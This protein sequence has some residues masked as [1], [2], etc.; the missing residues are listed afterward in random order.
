FED[1]EQL[2]KA[3][4]ESEQRDIMNDLITTHVFDVK[5]E[6]SLLSGNFEKGNVRSTYHNY[7][8]GNDP[9]KWKSRVGLYDYVTH[10]NLYNDIDLVV[11]SNGASMKYDLVLHPGGNINDISIFYDGVD[12]QLDNQGRLK[13]TT[14]VNEYYE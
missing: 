4:D 14:A 6:N 12:M 1:I 5:F 3:H 2:Q 8:L 9:S 13:I 10:S 7:F 11:Y